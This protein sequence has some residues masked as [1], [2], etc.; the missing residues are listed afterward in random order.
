MDL[1]VTRF[2]LYNAGLGT[3][4]PEVK[5]Q[6]E[7]IEIEERPAVVNAQVETKKPEAD[8][9]HVLWF[10][11][12]A[13]MKL[14]QKVDDK[15]LSEMFEMAGLPK[16]FIPSQEVAKRIETTTRN[17]EINIDNASAMANVEGLTKT[18]GFGQLNKIFEIS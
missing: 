5:Q 9:L 2:G 18:D 13:G 15:D 12:I 6:T 17:A 3:Q 8:S 16:K 4:K 11:N 7:K 1:D 14:P 10:Q